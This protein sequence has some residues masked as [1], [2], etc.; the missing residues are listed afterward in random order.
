MKERYRI[1]ALGPIPADLK[2]LI[3]EIHAS[4]ILSSKQ[5]GIPVYTEELKDKAVPKLIGRDKFKL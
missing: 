4:A 3:S 5:E 1:Y 2:E